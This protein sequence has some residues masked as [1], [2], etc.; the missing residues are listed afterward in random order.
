MERE[1]SSLYFCAWTPSGHET[2]RETVTVHESSLGRNDRAENFGYSISAAGS[3]VNLVRDDSRTRSFSWGGSR[4]RVRQDESRTASLI[5]PASSRFIWGPGNET[6]AR[7]RN[8][9]GQTV[10]SVAE[11]RRERVGARRARLSSPPS[12]KYAGAT[13]NRG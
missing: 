4:G 6:R 12:C 7:T 10:A 1:P 9:F 8:L 11:A 13:E 3:T 2:K 5:K